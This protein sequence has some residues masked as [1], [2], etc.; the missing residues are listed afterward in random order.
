MPVDIHQVA[1][2]EKDG[3]Q[4]GKNVALAISFVVPTAMWVGQFSDKQLKFRKDSRNSNAQ[5]PDNI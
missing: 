5:L 2:T 4:T 1:L 3:K